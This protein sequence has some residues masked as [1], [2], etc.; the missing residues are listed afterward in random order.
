MQLLSFPY[1]LKNGLSQLSLASYGSYYFYLRF[2]PFLYFVLTILWIYWR[3]MKIVNMSQSRRGNFL[4]IFFVCSLQKP[5]GYHWFKEVFL[6]LFSI[7]FSI[8]WGNSTNPFFFCTSK[9]YF[10]QIIFSHKSTIEIFLIYWNAHLWFFSGCLAFDRDPT[11]F[12]I[13]LFF[14]KI[15]YIHIIYQYCIATNLSCCFLEEF[16]LVLLLATTWRP[17][18]WVLRKICLSE[19]LPFENHFFLIINQKVGY[20]AVYI[21]TEYFPKILLS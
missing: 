13:Y 16:H 12:Y 8:K 17:D 21:Y 9:Q 14:K 7:H 11:K 6:Q 15:I 2:S 4:T 5:I 1:F 19:R 18:L 3:I 10:C 20:P